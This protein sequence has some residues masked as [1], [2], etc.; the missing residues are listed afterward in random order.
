M[1]SI[2]VEENNTDQEKIIDPPFPRYGNILTVD[3][4]KII[5]P[6]FARYGNILSVSPRSEIQIV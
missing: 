1:W 3:Q 2:I 6:P 5:D 4:E